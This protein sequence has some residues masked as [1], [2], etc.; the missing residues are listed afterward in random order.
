[1]NARARG[2]AGSVGA[3]LAASP[4]ISVITPA[5]NSEPWVDEALDSLQGQ[6]FSDWELIFVDDG[7]TDGTLARAQARAKKDRRI[8]VLSQ[9]RQGPSSAR[10]LALSRVRGRFLAFLDADDFWV[11]AKLETQLEFMR[12]RG[13]VFSYTAY[14]CVDESGLREIRRRPFIP[15]VSRQELLKSC[16]ISISSVML[17]SRVWDKVRFS[18]YPVQEDYAFWFDLLAEVERAYGIGEVL[19]SYRLHRASRSADKL[20]AVMGQWNVYRR[21]LELSWPLSLFYLGHY[22][23]AAVVNRLSGRA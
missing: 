11:P 13:C 3:G 4:E 21:H 2:K 23:L 5:H 15:S 1:M 10:N 17:G 19:C 18:A 22:S 9:H 16:P 8:L 12:S 7:S 20:R 6:T 14:N